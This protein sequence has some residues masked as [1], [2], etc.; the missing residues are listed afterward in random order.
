MRVYLVD[1]ALWNTAVDKHPRFCVE[2]VGADKSNVAKP[3]SNRVIDGIGGGS[4]SSDERRLENGRKPVSC[5][6]KAKAIRNLDE[7]RKKH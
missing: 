7:R 6:R 4:E 2:R 5:E 1:S 3:C